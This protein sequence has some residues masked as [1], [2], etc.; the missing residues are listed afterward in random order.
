MIG[1]LVQAGTGVATAVAACRSERLVAV[2]GLYR[3]LSADGKAEEA[4]WALLDLNQW[5]LPCQGSA[6]A[7][8]S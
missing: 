3:K 7:G 8:L 1:S 6:L 4:L 2:F 5:P